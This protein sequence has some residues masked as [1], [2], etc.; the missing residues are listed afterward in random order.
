MQNKFSARRLHLPFPWMEGV[1]CWDGH[2]TAH[3]PNENAPKLWGRHRGGE[4][5]CRVEVGGGLVQRVREARAQ[6]M[7]AGGGGPHTVA[8]P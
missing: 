4:L 5:S 7:A 1:R 6:S 3:T 8:M 2:T